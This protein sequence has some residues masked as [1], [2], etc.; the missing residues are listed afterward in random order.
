MR[1]NFIRIAYCVATL[2][3]GGIG[4]LG[5]RGAEFKGDCIFV[6]GNFADTIVGAT[7]RA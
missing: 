3:L 4:N 5:G 1:R 7:V 6:F 2:M